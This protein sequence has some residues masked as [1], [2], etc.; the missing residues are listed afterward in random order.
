MRNPKTESVATLLDLMEDRRT[1]PYSI[2]V[3]AQSLDAGDALAGRIGGLPEVDETITLSNYVPA[4]QTEKLEAIE[5]MA[6]FIL[7][8][9]AAT[10]DP[11]PP[12]G[13]AKRSRNFAGRS[14]WPMRC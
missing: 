10:G 2:T 3:L 13:A 7:P 5:S 4:A 8:S 9:L 1:S 6:M 12:I 11:R 14:R